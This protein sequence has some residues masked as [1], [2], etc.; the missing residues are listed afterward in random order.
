VIS[1]AEKQEKLY[2]VMDDTTDIG[3]EKPLYDDKAM[4]ISRKLDEDLR[5]YFK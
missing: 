1:V 2:L 4:E 3:A 5:K